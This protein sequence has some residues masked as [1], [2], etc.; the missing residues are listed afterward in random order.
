PHAAAPANATVTEGGLF[1]SGSPSATADAATMWPCPSSTV[2]IAVT[3]P[4]SLIVHNALAP[5]P[6]AHPDH[7]KPKASP[8]G[9]DA[10]AATSSVHENDPCGIHEVP[11]VSLT[12]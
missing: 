8:S 4:G 9:S 11:A 5:V 3:R 1:G 7:E 12:L 6:V 2:T 10:S